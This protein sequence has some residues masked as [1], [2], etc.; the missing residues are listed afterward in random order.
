MGALHFINKRNRKKNILTDYGANVFLIENFVFP[1]P[2]PLMNTSLVNIHK[3]NWPELIAT[4]VTIF[5]FEQTGAGA[6]L[7]QAEDKLK[8]I[9]F[10]AYGLICL[11]L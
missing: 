8:L 3:D 11:V 1:S 2:Y 7:W 4:F 10:G 9:C 6:D 5:I